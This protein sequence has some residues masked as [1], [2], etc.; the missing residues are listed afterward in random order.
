MHVIADRVVVGGQLCSD[1]QV[2]G[3]PIPSKRDRIREGGQIAEWLECRPLSPIKHP[4][5]RD[6]MLG[7]VGSQE[8]LHGLRKGGEL[9]LSV[10]PVDPA[11]EAPDQL[12]A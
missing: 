1:R 7:G 11:V 10:D 8:P 6:L 5:A 9:L 12:A 2:V 4:Q 3:C